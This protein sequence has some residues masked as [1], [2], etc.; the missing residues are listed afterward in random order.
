MKTKIIDLYEAFIEAC[1]E[2]KEYRNKFFNSSFIGRISDLYNTK[3][4]IRKWISSLEQNWYRWNNMAV[5]R[6]KL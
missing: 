3:R 5:F 6:Y 1:K 4:A 2:S